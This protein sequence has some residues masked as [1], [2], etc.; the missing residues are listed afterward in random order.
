MA[1]SSSSSEPPL[2]KTPVPSAGAGNRKRLHDSS[3]Q[4]A[5]CNIL[6]GGVN[7]EQKNNDFLCPICFSV[8]EEAHIAK[9]G[10][11][12]CYK[13]ILKSLKYS[14]QC[15]TCRGVIGDSTQLFPN[16]SLNDM[17]LKFKRNQ[18]LSSSYSSS[19]SSSKKSKLAEFLRS[20]KIGDFDLPEVNDLLTL[21]SAKKSALEAK[22][23]LLDVLILKEF[24]L[25]LKQKKQQKL[26][27][28]QNELNLINGDLTIVSEMEKKHQQSTLASASLFPSSAALPQSSPSAA[29][30]EAADGSAADAFVGE[31]PSSSALGE[32]VV[33]CNLEKLHSASSS[34]AELMI[35]E[36]QYSN[37]IK[38]VVDPAQS[39]AS[40]KRK[41][42]SHFDDLQT[43]YF[44]QR[45][46]DQI[47]SHDDIADGDTGNMKTQGMESFRDCLSKFTRFSRLVPLATLNYAADICNASNIV[48]SIEFDASGD[49]FAIA[50]VTRRIKIF[51]YES[52]IKDLV[53]IHY[54][55]A[56]M[57]CNSKISCIC[58][59]SYHRGVLASSDY[60][61][62]VSLWDAFSGCTTKQ[63]QE[64]EK[65]CWSCDFSTTNPKLLVSGSDDHQVKIWS[66]NQEH[67][68]HSISAA[69][70]VC[71]VKFSPSD[72]F[73]L[74][75]GS[76]DH[77]VHL[78]D[79]RKLKTPLKVF[80]GHRKA[81]SYTRFLGPTSIVSASTDSQLK[82]WDAREDRARRTFSGHV[83]EKNFVGLATNSATNGDYIACGSENNTLYVY[84]KGLSKTLTTYKF[85]F[86]RNV[87]DGRERPSETSHSND[88]VSAVTWKHDSN[89]LVAAN[90]L[91]AIK[92]FEL[93]P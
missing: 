47:G 65:R 12:F 80:K 84:Y 66:M 77:S 42:H 92:I 3:A 30:T 56:E 88:F 73:K 71:C 19:P 35:Q 52:V 26:D 34:N 55:I 49:H 89:I 78:H 61:G 8:I 28:L 60:E 76:A 15:P 25:T 20:G 31:S 72:A 2:R 11:S 33:P 37:E 10:H 4:L 53:D 23:E 13:C 51:E 79:L 62:T 17:A 40:R 68:V 50:G 22:S 87:L 32:S 90:S 86:M 24:L 43:A 70:N 48:S 69:A 44:D 91:G 67:S 57:S 36:P 41:L 14:N 16:H 85:D 58:W 46:K 82:L 75:Y 38:N 63:F 64:H 1:Q 7:F 18:S 54:P 39:F 27:Q 81:V 6:H 5:S 21:L 93:L 59:N 74:V 83:N 9:C 29:A 45:L